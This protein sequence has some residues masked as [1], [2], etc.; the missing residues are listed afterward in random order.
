MCS[1]SSADVVNKSISIDSGNGLTPVPIM[2]NKSISIDS[3]NG[4]TPVP[5]MTKIHDT[6]WRQINH[7][8]ANP[9]TFPVAWSSERLWVPSDH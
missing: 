1:L 9:L 3:G 6:V 5:I 4:L 7:M 8:H 2:T